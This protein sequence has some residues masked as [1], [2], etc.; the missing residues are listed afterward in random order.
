MTRFDLTAQRTLVVAGPAS[1]V[2]VEGSATILAAPLNPESRIVVRSEKQFP[3]FAETDCVIEISVGEGARTSEHP[4][5]TIPTSW[6]SAAEALL[7]LG[8]GTVVVLGGTDVGKSTLSTFLTNRLVGSGL[9]VAF[10][11]ADIGQSDLGP[12][13]TIG[14]KVIDEYVHSVSYLTPDRMYFA[15]DN[16]PGRIVER[17]LTGIARI[18]KALDSE[19]KFSIVNTDGWVSDDFAVTYKLRLLN[20]VHPTMVIGI[21]S[22]P[23]ERILKLSKWPSLVVQPSEVVKL[24]SRLDRKV[25]REYAYRRFLEG[26]K[27]WAFPANPEVVKI[28]V[29][30]PGLR[31]GSGISPASQVNFG[32]LIVG[33]LNRDGFTVGIG[34]LL[35][36]DRRQQAIKIFSQPHEDIAGIEI[37]NVRLA[38]DGTEIGYLNEDMQ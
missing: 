35:E 4:T 37:G 20:D 23:V 29:E 6:N 17:V 38:Q 10:I 22:E 5:T 8:E 9:E 13:A 25:L 32:N 11:D 19:G 14:G 16:S 28:V 15:G 3:I 12:P 26:G 21:N 31:A 33:L 34:I 24:R 7:D 30:T 36:Y 18:A 2:L 27:V 1:V